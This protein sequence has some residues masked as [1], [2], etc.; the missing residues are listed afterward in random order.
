M[1]RPSLTSATG[2]TIED[3]TA[4]AAEGRRVTVHRGRQT[5]AVVPV[6]DLAR[7]EE[8][9]REEDRL[10]GEAAAAAKA[11]AEASGEAPLPWFEADR[12]LGEL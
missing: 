3:A 6:S 8:L 11:E 10:L 5:V 9:D 4:A 1:A 7:L 2:T 12:R